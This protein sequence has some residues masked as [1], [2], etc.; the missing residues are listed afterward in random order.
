MKGAGA[1][2]QATMAAGSISARART[3]G[4]TT[5]VAASTWAAT[6]IPAAGAT[7]IPESSRSFSRGTLRVR[8]EDRLLHGACFFACT[9][10]EKSRAPRDRRPR[11]LL[12]REQHRARKKPH[13]K[14]LR[15]ADERI[16]ARGIGIE[17]LGGE[18]KQ[19]QHDLRADF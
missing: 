17:I 16:A 6:T 9:P 11:L 15:I 12:L 18:M 1:A 4:T 14:T 3:T 19:L 8:I 2:T 5:A 13:D 7:T 10:S